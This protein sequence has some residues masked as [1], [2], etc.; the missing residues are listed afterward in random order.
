VIVLRVWYG[1][2]DSSRVP[3][4]MDDDEDEADAG[5]AGNEDLRP[6]PLKDGQPLAHTTDPSPAPVSPASRSHSS[7]P[8]AAPPPSPKKTASSI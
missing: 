3:E 7:T 1:A 6:E 8:T 4:I 2:N 5:A